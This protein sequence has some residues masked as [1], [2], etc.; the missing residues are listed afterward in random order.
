MHE[1]D[2]SLFARHLDGDGSALLTLMERHGDPLTYYLNGYL[3]DLDAA[4]DLMMEAFAR[5]VVRRP[6]LREGGF[7]PYLY[8]VGRNLAIRHVRGTR[9]L[10]S[11]DAL[12]MEPEVEEA[13]EA[14]LI[15]NEEELALYRSMALIPAAYRE[16]LYLV[17][18]EGMSYDEAGA[19]MRRTRKQVDNLVQ[20]GKRAARELI[21][22][23]GVRRENSR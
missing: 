1:S 17:Y 19:V 20:R 9:M 8:K 16:A 18:V 15:A 3:H 21:E 6:L 12:P 11:L 5:L 2:E 23:K 7:K 22:A 10:V 4:E 14:R 13:M